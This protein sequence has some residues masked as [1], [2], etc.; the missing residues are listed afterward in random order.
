[1]RLVELADLVRPGVRPAE[2]HPQ[3][4]D[5]VAERAHADVLLDTGEEGGRHAFNDGDVVLTRDGIVRLRFEQL[6]QLEVVVR[7]EDG[8]TR[9]AG[10][11]LDV[12]QQIVF[13]ERGE[14]ADV[15]ERRAETAP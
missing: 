7:P 6:L 15:K 8:A 13:G 10:E 1:M 5:R 4:V 12:P 11:D 9:Y 2:V 14:H 3:V